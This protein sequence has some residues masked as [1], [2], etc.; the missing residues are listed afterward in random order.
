MFVKFLGINFREFK[1]YLVCCFLMNNFNYYKKKNNIR[2]NNK[3]NIEM[4]IWIIKI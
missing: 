4:K 2:R 1:C 3:I